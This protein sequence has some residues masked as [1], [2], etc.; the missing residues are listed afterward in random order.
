MTEPGQGRDF[1]RTLYYVSISGFAVAGMA[2]FGYK[3]YKEMEE[4]KQKDEGE[5]R[6][7]GRREDRD[8]DRDRD[9][10]INLIL[11]NSR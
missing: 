10:E 1:F 5:V 3:F 11:L 2:Y 6:D 9:M 8:R 4:K 7:K